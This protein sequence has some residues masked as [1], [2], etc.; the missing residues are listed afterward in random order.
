MNLSVNYWNVIGYCF[1]IAYPSVLKRA[2]STLWVVLDE[3]DKELRPIKHYY[4]G[5]SAAVAQATKALADQ[6]KI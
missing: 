3:L 4:L 6:G 1:D 2:I 5:N